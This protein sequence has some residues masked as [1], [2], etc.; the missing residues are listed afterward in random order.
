VTSSAIVE[1]ALTDLNRDRPKMQKRLWIVT[2]MDSTQNPP[3]VQIN[4]SP[5]STSPVLQDLCLYTTDVNISF[6]VKD[7]RMGSVAGQRFSPGTFYSA[8]E[9]V[10]ARLDNV[11]NLQPFQPMRNYWNGS[12]NQAIPNPPG[13]QSYMVQCFYDRT[14]KTSGDDAGN[15]GPT[16]NGMMNTTA[17]FD[18]PMLSPG[19]RMYVYNGP[20]ASSSSTGTGSGSGS[21][22]TGVPANDYTIR[23][24]VDSAPVNAPPSGNYFVQFNEQIPVGT[25]NFQTGNYAYRAGWLPPAV[26]VSLRI[27]DSKAKEM[28]TI[29]R[30]FKILAAS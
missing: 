20:Q 23:G 15:F 4:Q 8:E 22:A 27:K 1:Y 3:R 14:H 28:R 26:R 19:D 18:F 25:P 29:S 5:T 11:T 30:T 16:N 2:G 6:F 13:V 12:P 24:F 9:L 17:W 10:S 21:Q 7:K